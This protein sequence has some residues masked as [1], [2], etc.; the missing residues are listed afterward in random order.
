MIRFPFKNSASRNTG[1]ASKFLGDYQEVGE[2]GKP[3]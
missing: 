3:I 2:D 1:N